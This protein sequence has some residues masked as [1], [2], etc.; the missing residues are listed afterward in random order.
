MFI[1]DCEQFIERDGIWVGELEISR[2]SFA[3]GVHLLESL[4]KRPYDEPTS[5]EIRT[6]HAHLRLVL[7]DQQGNYT[8]AVVVEGQLL[9]ARVAVPAGVEGVNDIFK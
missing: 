2:I 3:C 1:N 5:S 9:L 6:L 8:A 7:G 4:N